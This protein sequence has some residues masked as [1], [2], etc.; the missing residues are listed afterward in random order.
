MSKQV[1]S[2]RFEVQELIA[3]G[4]M[5]AV[6]KVLDTKLDRVVALKVVHSHL[7]SDADFVERFRDEARKT[8]RLQGHPN[9]VQIFDVANDHGTEYLVMEYF[10]STNLRDQLRS[11]G[12][13]P[14]TDAVNVT[15]QIAQALMKSHSCDIIHRDI[16][17]AN[18]LLDNNQFVKLTDF[19]I[20]KALSDAP[21]TSTGQ[22]IGTLKYMSPE[23]AR[24]TILD[25]K[26]DLYSLGMVLYELVMG[27]N[28][29]KD[30]PNLA[31]YG[32]LQ[33]ES[34]IPALEFSSDIPQGIRAVIQDLLR[35]DPT[36][37][38]QSAENLI[39]RLEDL[40]DIWDDPDATIVKPR[41]QEPEGLEDD[42]TVAVLHPPASGPSGQ[43]PVKQP[44]KQAKPI[45]SA[46]PKPKKIAIDGI[47]NSI[48]PVESNTSKTIRN[49]MIAAVAILAIGGVYY[50]NS[51]PTKIATNIQEN[52]KTIPKAITKVMDVREESQPLASEEIRVTPINKTQSAASKAQVAQDQ[53]AEERRVAEKAARTAQTQAEAKSQ[54]AEKARKVQARAEAEAQAAEAARV[55]QAEA[56]EAARIKE[57]ARVAQA[58]AAAEARAAE[59]A[60]V[61]EARAAATAKANEAARIAEEKAVAKA[62]AAEKA[63]VSEANAAA[64]AKAAE[65]ARV[66]EAKAAKRAQAA[67]QARIA[68]AKAAAQAQAAEK[69]RI[70]EAKAAAQAQAAEKA[71][72]A[73]AEAAA[74]AQAEEKARVAKAKAAAQA[75]AAEKARVA[76]AEAVARAQA[77]EKARVAEAQ[78]AEKTR[79]AEAKAAAQAA[80]I[81]ALNTLLAKLQRSIS[82]RDLQALQSMS[83]MSASRQK[84]LED[85]FARYQTIETS[86]GDLTRTEDQATVILQFTKFVRPNGE[87]VKPSR[88]LKTTN[89]VIPK[90]SDG[91]GLL[92]W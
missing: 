72:I 57:A 68:E 36:D 38:I 66:A 92:N 21:L 9:I 18:I 13:F 11:Q 6:Y 17:P 47:P 24:N 16:K 53:A 86:I 65:E 51:L 48:D 49:S 52:T 89:V 78:A 5:G 44:E 3:E 30:V 14:L 32:N 28:I 19:G 59:E 55:A 8:A 77:A 58:Q 22:L 12:K 25:G 33:A 20:A 2:E 74:Q 87:I 90:K 81:Q 7:S 85:L 35:F 41:I 29:W 26:T 69:A 75:K 42:K 63:R 84:M 79:I 27:K 40:R 4:G 83:T 31:I 70:A 37:R 43:K 67:E 76:E 91:W 23:Q 71:R 54:A 56:I 80:E 1:F 62:P 82:K 39:A 88:F 10:P 73:E 61:A 50:V 60:R 15:R 34:T 46:P 45:K 64:K